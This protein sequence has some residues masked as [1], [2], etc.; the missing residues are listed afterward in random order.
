MISLNLSPPRRNIHM[1][2]T[3]KCWIKCNFISVLVCKRLTYVV[4][5]QDAENIKWIFTSRFSILSQNWIIYFPNL[6]GDF[7]VKKP[8]NLQYFPSSPLNV[9]RS[10]HIEVSGLLAFFNEPEM[11][12]NVCSNEF[13]STQKCEAKVVFYDCELPGT[14]GRWRVLLVTTRLDLC[15]LMLALSFLGIFVWPWDC[16]QCTRNITTRN[17]NIVNSLDIVWWLCLFSASLRR[18][19]LNKFMTLFKNAFLST[20]HPHRHFVQ[21]Q[22]TNQHI[23]IWWVT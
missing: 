16:R 21:P 8:A 4:I 11:Q 15:P 2:S 13:C 22:P 20:E 19:R 23:L 1:D 17:I 9:L 10:S 5:P 12:V 6:M 3:E 14:P 18:E 7:L